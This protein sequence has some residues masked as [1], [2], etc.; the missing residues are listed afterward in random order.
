MTAG[1]LSNCWIVGGHRPPLQSLIRQ[2]QSKLNL[3][4]PSYGRRDHTGSRR[5]HPT[6]VREGGPQRRHSEI[7][8]IGRVERFRTELESNPLG[9]GKR[10]SK[11]HVPVVNARLSEDIASTVAELTS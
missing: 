10:L 2:F 5:R 3:P 6:G 11:V 9:N 1:D 7:R 4:R 8:V